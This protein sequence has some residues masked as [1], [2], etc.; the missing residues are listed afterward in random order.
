MSFLDT[1]HAFRQH[2]Q[3]QEAKRL[4]KIAQAQLDESRRRQPATGEQ[5]AYTRGVGD[6]YQRGYQQALADVATGRASM[7]V[8][9]PTAPD[10]RE[11]RR[12]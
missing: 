6:G 8:P 11:G 2:S 12:G 9:E 1:L 3:K 5:A 7:V 10:G 4:R